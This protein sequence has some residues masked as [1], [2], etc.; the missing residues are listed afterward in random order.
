MP[1]APRALPRMMI[2]SDAALSRVVATA[3][4]AGSPADDATLADL[5]GALEQAHRVYSMLRDCEGLAEDRAAAAARVAALARRRADHADADEAAP[6]ARALELAAR[7]L[8]EEGDLSGAE[9]LALESAEHW[10]EAADD[11]R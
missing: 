9:S 11:D 4:K 6:R 3:K 10:L 5:D 2:D 8:R 7:T 1:E